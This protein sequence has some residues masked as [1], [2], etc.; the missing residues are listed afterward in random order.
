MEGRAY[1][2]GNGKEGLIDSIRDPLVCVDEFARV[3]YFLRRL[4][5]PA[6]KTNGGD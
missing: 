5:P 4:R 3:A 1:G 2:R 6:F